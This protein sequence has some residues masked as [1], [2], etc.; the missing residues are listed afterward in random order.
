M[1]FCISWFQYFK[2]M[3]RSQ[4]KKR[5]YSGCVARNACAKAI[6]EQILMPWLF[7]NMP[8]LQQL[9][10]SKPWKHRETRCCEQV[11]CLEA[12]F[13]SCCLFRFSLFMMIDVRI[14]WNGLMVV[15]LCSLFLPFVFL[16]CLNANRF[17]L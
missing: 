11:F 9:G 5:L 3:A 2:K 8:T 10:M 16:F 13:V 14:V 6:T 12:G 1:L 7:T 15:I 4:K 17:A